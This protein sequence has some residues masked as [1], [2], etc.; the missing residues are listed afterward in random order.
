MNKAAVQE[1]TL[2]MDNITTDKPDKKKPG[3]PKGS[4]SVGTAVALHQH[5]APAEIPPPATMLQAIARAAADPKVDAAK[6]RELLDMHKEIMAD[7]A[8]IAFTQAFVDLQG[9]LPVI[10]AK[11]RIV[12]EGKQGKAGQNTPYATFNEINRVTKPLLQ[13]HGFCLS[14]ATEPGGEGRLL[15][16][17]YLDH[18]RGHRRETIF[19]LPAETSG[20]KNNVQGYGSTMSYGK[21]YA[22]IALLNL[23]S[24]SQEDADMD[25]AAVH[26]KISTDQLKKLIAIKDDVGADI[27]RFCTYLKVS[28]LADLPASRFEEAKA[29]LEAKRKPKSSSSEKEKS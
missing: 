23:V 15:V 26:E 10:N 19:P 18:V 5:K 13:A 4:K 1:P 24:E 2:P 16:K 28:A 22:T 29:A 11:G 21:R 3:R 9:Q 12:I 7:E 8:K 25:G 20:S 27:V 6:M 17:G 14:F